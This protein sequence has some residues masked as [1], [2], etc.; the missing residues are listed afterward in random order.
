MSP[1][2]RGLHCVSLPDLEQLCREVERGAVP[3]PMTA[4]ALAAVHLSH[5][6]PD[7]EGLQTLDRVTVAAVLRAV[8]AD[9]EHQRHPRLELV[10]TGPETPGSTTR[11]TAIVVRELFASA[12]RSVLVAGF[13]FDCGATIFEPVHAAM[14]DRAVEASFF[15]DIGRAPPGVAADDHVS[16]MVKQFLAENWPFGEPFPQ[17]FYDP[18]TIA[19]SSVASIHAKCVVVDDE[20]A[21]VTSANFTDRGQ[22]RNIEVGVLIEDAGFARELGGQWRRLGEAGL[23]VQARAAS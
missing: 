13:A 21:L 1:Q 3:M 4:S 20:R 19:P 23:V 7:V 2:H 14:R 12:R 18:R 6:A 8:V 22:T 16:R 10:W 15:L 11:D 5:V 17:V 9:R